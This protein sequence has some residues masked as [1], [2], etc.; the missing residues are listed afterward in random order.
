MSVASVLSI[1]V[2]EV[3]RV[4]DDGDFDA[5]H[6]FEGGRGAVIFA[7]VDFCVLPNETDGHSIEEFFSGGYL[8]VKV[9]G[10]ARPLSSGRRSL[11]FG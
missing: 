2:E 11:L 10:S 6:S 1:P 4:D 3:D 7:A 8:L 9:E 5:S